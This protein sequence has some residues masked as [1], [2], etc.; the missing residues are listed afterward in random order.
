MDHNASE[1][2]VTT[3]E[4]AAADGRLYVPQEGWQ[5][6]V[7]RSWEKEYCYAQNPGD[8]FFHLLLS[9]EVYLQRDNEKYCLTCALR[10]GLI[11]TDRLYWQRPGRR[12]KK[13]GRM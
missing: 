5:A 11:T 2:S 4:S 6:R 8:D 7:K 13:A 12:L 1:S 3:Q 9:G 10:N